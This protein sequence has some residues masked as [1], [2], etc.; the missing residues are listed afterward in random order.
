VSDYEPVTNEEGTMEGV[1]APVNEVELTSDEQHNSTTKS[2]VKKKQNTNTLDDSLDGGKDNLNEMDSSSKKRGLDRTSP[3]VVS[4]AS[5]LTSN[6]RKKVLNESVPTPGLSS[7]PSE[8]GSLGLQ[9]SVISSSDAINS[10]TLSTATMETAVIT[11]KKRKT[12]R[13]QK[14]VVNSSNNATAPI[15]QAVQDEEM[16][17]ESAGIEIWSLL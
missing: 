17:K 1:F 15:E 10:T 3:F 14:S 5:A 6:K 9:S 8:L 11:K 4:E 2:K 13:K 12:K 16:E 7:V